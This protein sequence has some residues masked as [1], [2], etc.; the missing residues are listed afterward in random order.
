MQ[1]ERNPPQLRARGTQREYGSEDNNANGNAIQSWKWVE[2]I[3]KDG[4][5]S[6]INK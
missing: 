2:I 6:E 1:R 4:L 5:I 3:Y